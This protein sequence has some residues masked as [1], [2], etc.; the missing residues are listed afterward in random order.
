MERLFV[1]NLNVL[2]FTIMNNNVFYACT[3][4]LFAASSFGSESI[5]EHNDSWFYFFNR[6]Y[7]PMQ[8]GKLAMEI[9]LHLQDTIFTKIEAG[10]LRTVRRAICEKG[11][12]ASKVALLLERS[13]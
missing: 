9:S 4:N 11:C 3:F 6:V 2:D 5:V 7:L 10:G 1:A 12:N 13:K 8:R